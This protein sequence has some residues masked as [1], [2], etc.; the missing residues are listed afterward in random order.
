LTEERGQYL[1]SRG[2]KLTISI[3]GPAEIHDRCRRFPDGRGSHAK[4][5]SNL[6]KLSGKVTAEVAL[7]KQDIDILPA[8]LHY[9]QQMGFADVIINPME[10]NAHEPVFAEEDWRKLAQMYNLIAASCASPPQ[11][12]RGYLDRVS[13]PAK[14]LYRCFA[15]QKDFFVAPDGRIFPCPGFYYLDAFDM[16]HVKTGVD[17]QQQETLLAAQVDNILA[18]QRC[19]ARY[20][21]GGPCFYKAFKENGCLSAPSARDC[22][23]AQILIESALRFRLG[24]RPDNAEQVYSRSAL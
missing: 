9:L 6:A 5:V 7:A 1:S 12:I 2:V 19:W 4:V 23:Q 22:Q 13:N 15:G 8:T 10:F 20:F 16:G 14:K 11:S 21:C 24:E 3:D 17:T 18:C